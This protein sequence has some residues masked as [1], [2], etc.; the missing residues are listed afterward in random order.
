MLDI[1]TRPSAVARLTGE[2]LYSRIEGIVRFYQLPTQTLVVAEVQG[3]PDSQTGFFA[4]HIHVGGNCRG[5]GYPKTS[6]HYNPVGAPHP[7]HAGDLPPLLSC[8]GS[9]FLA[10]K[11]DRFRAKE[12]LGRTIIVHSQ[13]DDFHTQPSGNPGEKIACGEILQLQ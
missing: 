5:T 12:V 1:R 4:F 7:S 2:G 13:P 3:L 8:K 9:A 11:T 6:G 10:V